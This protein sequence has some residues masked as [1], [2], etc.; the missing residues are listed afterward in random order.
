MPHM[1]HLLHMRVGFQHRIL[2]ETSP[3]VGTIIICHDYICKVSRPCNMIFMWPPPPTLQW[4]QYVVSDTVRDR[5][6]HTHTLPRASPSSPWRSGPWSRKGYLGR[7][8]TPALSW[9]KN[10]SVGYWWICIASRRGNRLEVVTVL[11]VDKRC[12]SLKT[13]RTAILPYTGAPV[14]PHTM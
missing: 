6:L 12:W 1:Q 2:W 7:L 14:I 10:E 11:M 8:G 5:I 3:T 4:Y 13:T 9:I